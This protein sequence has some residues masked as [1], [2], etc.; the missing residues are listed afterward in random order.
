MMIAM[1]G[2]LMI[3]ISIV[4]M[5]S[6]PSVNRLFE[7]RASSQSYD[8]GETGRFGRQGYAFELALN[9]PLGIGPNEF[10]T[11]RVTELPH[12]VYVNVLL[13]Y[14]WGGGFVFY[15]LVLATVWRGLSFV[16]RPGPNRL[17]LI[18]LVAVFV[19]LAIEAAIID[20]DHWRHFF[21]VA[22]L[23]WGVTAAYERADKSQRTRHAA[24]I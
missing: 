23:I 6:I 8:E 10:S 7:I 3:G 20:L 13:V 18:P 1:A 16:I 11:K 21:L 17:L 5:L 15:V 19:P 2:V 22:G 14:G 24:I 12:N 9:N 4:G